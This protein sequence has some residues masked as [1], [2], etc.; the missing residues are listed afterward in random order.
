MAD[1]DVVKKQGGSS[2]LMWLLLAVA[3]VVVAWMLLGRGDS[4]PQ[5]SWDRTPLGRTAVSD[6]AS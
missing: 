5:S 3:A 4:A 6:V 2:W 1:I